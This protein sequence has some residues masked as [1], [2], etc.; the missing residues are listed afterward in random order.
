MLVDGRTGR[1]VVE[2]RHVLPGVVQHH[3]APV[4]VLG[5]RGLHRL[6]ELVT[7]KQ[8]T[9]AVLVAAA[10]PGGVQTGDV[11]SRAVDLD[12]ALPPR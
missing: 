4:G 6:G 7:A 12:Y 10:H 2:F 1:P 11:Q 3:N 5:L 9:A 8:Q